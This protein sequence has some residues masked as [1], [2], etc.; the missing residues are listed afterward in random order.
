[1]SDQ[2]FFSLPKADP[3]SFGS[4]KSEEKETAKITEPPYEPPAPFL[5][6]LKPKKLRT[7]LQAS[8]GECFSSMLSSRSHPMPNFLRI[9]ARRREHIKRRR[10][11]S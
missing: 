8:K 2:N 5:N 3:S 10:R 11:S 6:R 1:M 4:N 7:Y 9:C